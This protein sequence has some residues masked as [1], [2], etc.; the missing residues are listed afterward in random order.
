MTIERYAIFRYDLP[1]VMPMQLTGQHLVERRGYIIALYAQDGSTGYGEIAP[2]PGLHRET[3]EEAFLQVQYVLDWLTGRTLS[4]EL[5]E[6]N[7]ALEHLLASYNLAP[8]VRTG[9]EMALLNV[10]AVST[11]ATLP[12]LL[13]PHYHETIPLNGLL[14]GSMESIANGARQ[15]LDEGYRTL[16]IKVGRLPVE[17]EIA[18]V[19]H[20]RETVG[21]GLAL[22]L[23]ANRSWT[24]QTA[25][26]FGEAVADCGIEYIEEPLAEPEHLREFVQ[27]TGIVVALDES[28]AAGATVP[29]IDPAYIRA[30]VLKPAVIGGIERTM[31]YIR[32]ARQYGIDAVLS[33]AFETGV[34]LSVYA[35]LA[36]VANERETACGLDTYKHLAEDIPVERFRAQDG[37]VT[38]VSNWLHSL[39]LRRELLQPVASA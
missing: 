16:K 23:D 25:M 35:G 5:A 28:L 6:C 12:A 4:H 32:L 3:P 17:Q 13:S 27:R 31:D 36:A 10:L 2:L 30:M 9:I 1:F 8:S 24:L 11:G 20:V 18:L 34:S 29:E 7:G 19:R 33:S 22:R 15:L 38:T 26:S 39:N 14:S 21:S 37:R